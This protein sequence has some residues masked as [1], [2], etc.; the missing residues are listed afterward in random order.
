MLADI[1]ATV[2][3]LY[4]FSKLTTLHKIGKNTLFEGVIITRNNIIY[5]TV[6][7]IKACK[8]ATVAYLVSQT[9]EGK[10]S[11]ANDQS[12]FLKVHQTAAFVVFVLVSLAPRFWEQSVYRYLNSK[13]TVW[14]Q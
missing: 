2:C 4:P 13:V 5:S 3:V 11:Y 8:S 10:W 7:F 6:A 12:A 14:I 9:I 1:S